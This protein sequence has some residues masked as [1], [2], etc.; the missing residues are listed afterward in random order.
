MPD[1]KIFAGR[2]STSFAD[3][4]CAYLGVEKGQSFSKKFSEGNIYVRVDESIRDKDVYIVQ[5]I[6]IDP[7][8]EF[9]EL[10]FWIDAFKRAS[11]ANI[12]AVIPY[13]SYAKGDKKDEPRVSIRGKVCADCIEKVGVDRVITMDLHAPQVQGFFSKPVD[14]LQYR[15]VLAEYARRLGIVNDDL[16]VVSP[17]AGFAKN[18][19]QFAAELGC[20]TAIG[21]KTRSDHSEHA[22]ILEIIGDVKNK[23]CLIVDDFTISGGTL[24][25]VAEGLMDKG[26]RNVLAF[27]SHA[28]VTSPKTVERINNSP[29]KLVVTTDTVECPVLAHSDKIRVISAAPLFAQTV[30]TIH[31]RKTTQYMYGHL[32]QKLY[33]AS[34]AGVST[35]IDL[36]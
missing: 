9:T 28:A 36:D 24:I 30:R 26:A 25:D 10:L 17:D 8:D 27:L 2:T 33:D 6:G 1:I 14:H 21:D 18:A 32:E 31:D 16:V 34:F 4:M 13:Y 35:H 29:L 11:A 19:R 3:K 7:N 5:T 12:T 15:K 22:E 23:N 20:L